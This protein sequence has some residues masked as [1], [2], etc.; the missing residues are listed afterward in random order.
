MNRQEIKIVDLVTISSGYTFRHKIEN[1]SDGDL[2]IVQP[3]DTKPNHINEEQVFK[4]QNEGI[5]DKF[6]LQKGDIL[7]LGKGAN[8]FAV[9][10]DSNQTSV[11]AS[12]FFVMRVKNSQII[13][14]EFLMFYLNSPVGQKQLNSGKEGTYVSNIS[15]KSLEELTVILPSLEEQEKLCRLYRL[16]DKE[17]RLTKKLLEKKIILSKVIQTNTISGK[18]TI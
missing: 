4:V 2:A 5:K 17:I 10:F 3:K 15:K 1:Q 12:S 7:F 14:S 11:A 13:L 9:R 6:F 18:Q 8:N 16:A